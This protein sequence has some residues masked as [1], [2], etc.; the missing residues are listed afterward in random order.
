VIR[1]LFDDR[2]YTPAQE[3][4]AALKEVAAKT[5]FRIVFPSMSQCLMIRFVSRRLSIHDHRSQ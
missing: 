1:L 5:M 2:G 3:S 4:S